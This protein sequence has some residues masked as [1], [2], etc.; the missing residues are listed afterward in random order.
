[1]TGERTPFEPGAC[2]SY[3]G[4]GLNYDDYIMEPKLDG[5][6][7]QIIVEGGV[8]RC[9]T[10]SLRE[11]TGRL[12]HVEEALAHWQ[13]GDLVIDG[14]VVYANGTMDF[15]FAASVM[16]SGEAVAV[17]KQKLSG[18]WLTVVCF[19]LLVAEGVDLRGWPIEER[20][21]ALEFLVGQLAIPYLT[22]AE[23]RDAS[24]ANHAHF[25]VTYGEGSVMKRRGSSYPKGRGAAW[26]K[27]KADYEEDVV[28]MGAEPGK[29]KYLGQV[30]ALIFGQ[31]RNGELT[32]RGS[33]GG[34]TDEDRQRF[35]DELPL[36]GVMVIRHNGILAL[37]HFRHPVFRGF[38]DDKRPEQCDWSEPPMRGTQAA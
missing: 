30:G 20:R 23:Q 24:P 11:V 28:V 10:R 32:E 36:G 13:G 2:K 19:D 14:E 38:R 18:K 9:F 6:R 12:P 21:Q 15:N 37:E 5:F 35:T 8:V 29:G 27:W 33:C 7:L 4:D 17:R 25:T 34:M 1:M 31:Y 16:G 3:A 26:L 22:L